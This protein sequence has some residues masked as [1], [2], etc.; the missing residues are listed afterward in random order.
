MFSKPP[1]SII[2]EA[3][4]LAARESME[5]NI[6]D[7]STEQINLAFRKLS[8]A[9]MP[10][11]DKR[12]RDPKADGTE[13][14]EATQTDVAGI[15]SA[16]GTDSDVDLDEDT[17]RDANTARHKEFHKRLQQLRA[18][19]ERSASSEL[20]NPLGRVGSGSEPTSNSR[21]ASA[22]VSEDAPSKPAPTGEEYVRIQVMM[23]LLRF[24]VQVL[25]VHRI[26]LL[27]G[28]ALV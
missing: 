7:L 2:K 13:P 10:L 19:R 16:D 3:L 27:S 15:C 20:E 9:H 1:Q 8:M 11:I 17:E 25:F 21:T 26:G 22:V 28:V 4:S 24:H 14:P 6:D 5:E 12:D 18:Q 23:E